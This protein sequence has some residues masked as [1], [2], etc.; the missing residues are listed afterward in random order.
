MLRG[1]TEEGLVLMNDPNSYSNCE[2]A[3]PIETL[4]KQAK[5]D[6]SFMVCWSND[7]PAFEVHEAKQES[8]ETLRGDIN[9]S[10]SVDIND[11]QLLYSLLSEGTAD[12]RYDVNGDGAVDQT[13][14]EALMD[15]ILNPKSAEGGDKV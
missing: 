2:M 1:V 4:L 9:D 7:M 3:F 8:G 5:T 10:G 14:L 12:E 6:E 13:D 11:A 15:M